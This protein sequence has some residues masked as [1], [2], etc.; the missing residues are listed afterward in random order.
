MKI[1]AKTD[2]CQRRGILVD[3]EEIDGSPI[4]ESTG[5]ANGDYYLWGEGTAEEL[6]TAARA[7]IGLYEGSGSPAHKNGSETAA[8]IISAL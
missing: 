4:N 8:L 2:T 3:P 7:D 6:L 1:F 5:E